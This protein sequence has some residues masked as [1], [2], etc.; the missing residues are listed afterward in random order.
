[1]TQ[2]QYTANQLRSALI[3]EHEHY[4]H[5]DTELMSVDEF[6]SYVSSLS[7]EQLIDDTGTDVEFT[8]DDFMSRYL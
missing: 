1:M 2:T 8:L 6:T 4:S 7:V 5:D 3:A